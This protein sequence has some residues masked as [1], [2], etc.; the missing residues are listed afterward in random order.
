MSDYL[1]PE[2]Y[3]SGKRTA[4]EWPDADP[5]P[6][7][8]TRDPRPEGVPEAPSAVI[9]LQRAAE[10]A[11]WAVLVGYSRGPERAVR[12]GTYKIT[13]AYGVHAAVH[14]VNGWRFVAVHSHTVG[15]GS[16]KWRVSIRRPGQLIGPG[17]GAVFT[18]ATITD[19]HEWL[20]VRGD[21]GAAWFKAVHARV[22]QQKKNQRA[23]ARN[24]PGKQKEGSR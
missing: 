1:T 13:E 19:L 14:P 9:K 7:V 11:G 5:P 15:S 10:A 24:R 23:A 22:E 12:V 6:E 3:R 20:A 2:Y 4:P 16:W 18:H 21:V 8:T 17:L